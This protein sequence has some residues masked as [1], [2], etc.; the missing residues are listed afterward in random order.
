MPS[1][2]CPKY[3]IATQVARRR[4]AQLAAIV[5]GIGV[6]PVE[7]MTYGTVDRADECWLQRTLSQAS[8]QLASVRECIFT[9]KR[10]PLPFNSRQQLCLQ[11]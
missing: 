4:Q 1:I 3:Q 10:S 9:L 2:S 8:T 5:K 11:G 7:V 6:A